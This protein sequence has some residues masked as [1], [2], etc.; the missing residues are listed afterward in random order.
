MARYLSS[1][2]LMTACGWRARSAP[3]QECSREEAGSRQWED[4]LGR[5]P[6]ARC[7]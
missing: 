1:V 6:H 7:H 5:R 4:R 2:R 3:L